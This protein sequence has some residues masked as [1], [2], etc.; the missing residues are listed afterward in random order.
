[1]ADFIRT[2]ISE[3]LKR[4]VRLILALQHGKPKTLKDLTQ[5]FG[6]SRR[7][8]FRDLS[9]LVEVGIEVQWC[10]STGTYEVVAIQDFDVEGLDSVDTQVLQ[11]CALST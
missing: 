7:T 1:M 4:L 3:R 10:R 6:V 2:N 9:L 8:V 11:P 5:I